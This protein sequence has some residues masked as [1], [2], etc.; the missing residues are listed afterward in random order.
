VYRTSYN[1]F[2][3]SNMHF[4][5]CS[6]YPIYVYLHINIIILG[7]FCGM[8]HRLHIRVGF[9]SSPLH[10]CCSFVEGCESNQNEI[11]V[12]CLFFYGTVTCFVT[13]DAVMFISAS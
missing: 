12:K 5:T 8:T 3:K 9:I 13:N 11:V 7:E 2:I 4:I 1:I 10:F 6:G